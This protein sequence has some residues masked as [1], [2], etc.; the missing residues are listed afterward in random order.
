M[1]KRIGH[2]WYSIHF[3]GHGY[4]VTPQGERPYFDPKSK[5]RRQ[6]EQEKAKQAL[7][8]LH[9]GGLRSISLS[10]GIQTFQ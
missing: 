6:M 9:D 1:G 8:F 4:R 3:I 5:S 7:W 10:L 2:I